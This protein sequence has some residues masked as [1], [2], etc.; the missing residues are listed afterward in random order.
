MADL[1]L[2]LSAWVDYDYAVSA[3]PPEPLTNRPD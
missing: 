3:G 1:F 2:D